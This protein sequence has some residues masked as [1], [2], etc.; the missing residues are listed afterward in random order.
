MLEFK[1]FV[2]RTAAKRSEG[3]LCPEGRRFLI[4]SLQYK[5]YFLALRQQTSAI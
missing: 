1:K 5:S 2:I 4:T 3:T